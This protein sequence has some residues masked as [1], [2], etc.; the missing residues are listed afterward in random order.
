MEEASTHFLDFLKEKE[1]SMEKITWEYIQGVPA[2]VNLVNMIGITLSEVAPEFNIRKTVGASWAGFYMDGIFIG[3]RFA[4][5]L[6]MVFEND[7][8]SNPTFKRDLY[9]EKAHFFS[10]TSGEQ[11]ECLI[12]FVRNSQK[13]YSQS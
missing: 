8:G 3:F 7:S 1:M 6:I 10:L 5:P 4:N 9:L 12:D 2:M 13:E 11:L